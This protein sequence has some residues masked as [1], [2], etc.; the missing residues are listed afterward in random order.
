MIET[1]H[2]I[3]R[4]QRVELAKRALDA[5][6]KMTNEEVRVLALTVLKADGY[7]VAGEK[8]K[9]VTT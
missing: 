6:E 5:P 2:L 1:V 8:M 7:V 3:T 4:K 9:P